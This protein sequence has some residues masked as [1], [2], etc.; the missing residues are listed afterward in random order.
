MVVASRQLT[1][2]RTVREQTEEIMSLL[3]MAMEQVCAWSK[4]V[5]AQTSESAGCDVTMW[6][7][8]L[9]N[10]EESLRQ[11]KA[12]LTEAE[13]GQAELRQALAAKEAELAAS[14][15][16]LAD[17]R[18]E[19]GSTD[20]LREELRRAQANVKSLR[21]R[22]GVLRGDV[23]EARQNEKRMSDAFEVMKSELDKKKERW[24]LIQ[25]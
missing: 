23:D 19:R 22:N 21:R 24:K 4:R 14:R 6:K 25:V 10:C 1:A 17:K 12:S 9:A 8:R 5:E 3:E 11:K 15:A 13:K 20:Q 2:E 16:E 7:N 18:R